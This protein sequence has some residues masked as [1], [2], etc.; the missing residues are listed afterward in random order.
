MQKPPGN[1][2]RDTKLNTKAGRQDNSSTRYCYLVVSLFFLVIT[3]L[4]RPALAQ[5]ITLN[6]GISINIL[7][8]RDA[9]TDL[10]GS[11]L[12]CRLA[13]ELM[14]DL[15]RSPVYTSSGTDCLVTDSF[16]ND[17][18]ALFSDASCQQPII[19]NEIPRLQYCMDATDNVRFGDGTGLPVQPAHEQWLL[20][21]G[22]LFDIGAASLSGLQQPYLQRV[23]YK[24]VETDRGICNLEMRIYRN[25]LSATDSRSMLALHGGSWRARG[26][27]FFGLEMTVP[28]LTDQGFVV[29]APFYRLID[30][31]EGMPACHDATLAQVREDA[32]DALRWVEQ[33][34]SL[35]GASDFP[36]VF[37]QSAGA[38]LAT[39]LAVD[40]PDRIANAV[41][42]Y[43]PTDFT[44]F[45]LRVIDGR[46]TNEQGLDIL[47]AVVGT[48]VEEFDISASPVPENSFPQQVVTNPTSFPPMFMLHGLADELVEATHSTRLC[49]A[50]SGDLEAVAEREFWIEQGDEQIVI[51]CDDR[52]SELHMIRQGDHA[53]DVC[54]SDNILLQQLCLS[55]PEQS[56]RLVADTVNGAAQWAASV[57]DVRAAQLDAGEI[58][59]VGTN[60]GNAGS[61]SRSGGSGS[62]FALLLVVVF[63]ALR[64][65]SPRRRGGPA[66]RLRGDDGV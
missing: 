4:P 65:S 24:Q 29:F 34:A 64:S 2:L 21:P 23:N 46:Y 39:S 36:T 48:T 60:D 7:E 25:D 1:N 6:N 15:E 56:R 16:S 63:V 30:T 19:L 18:N 62:S 43:P 52:G 13:E 10:L 9:L 22:N 12:A 11:A 37:G 26:F 55:G 31:D 41:L 53:L 17:Q 49:G 27:G 14:I 61:E 3:Q 42:F 20:S 57:A 38:H 58:G 59:G 35:Y 47:Q 44:D 5:E 33:N 66:S 40:F 45:G 8:D 51:D 54:L 28:R 32:A 50:L